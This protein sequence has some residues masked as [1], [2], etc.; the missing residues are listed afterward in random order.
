MLLRVLLPYYLL[1]LGS[2]VCG[3]PR[4]AQGAGL[5]RSLKRDAVLNPS[6][7]GIFTVKFGNVFAAVRFLQGLGYQ[8]FLLDVLD[9]AFPVVIGARIVKRQHQ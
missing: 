8:R 2:F 6:I 5:A 7:H 9:P 4:D 1:D 3:L